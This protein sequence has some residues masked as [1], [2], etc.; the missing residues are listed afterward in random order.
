MAKFQDPRGGHVRI[1]WS[2]LD[3]PAWRALSFSQQALYIA[4]RRKL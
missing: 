4:C 3:S 1:Y 2:I